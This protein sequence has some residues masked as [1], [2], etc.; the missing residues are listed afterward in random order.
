MRCLRPKRKNTK[1]LCVICKNSKN[2]KV[3][4]HLTPEEIELLKEEAIKLKYRFEVTNHGYVYLLDIFMLIDLHERLFDTDYI[5]D[6]DTTA[7]QIELMFKNICKF[8]S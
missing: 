4:K 1:E 7:E 6:L 8:I 5:G 2:F 3:A